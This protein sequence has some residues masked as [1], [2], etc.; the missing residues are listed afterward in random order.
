M[1]TS[2]GLFKT[3]LHLNDSPDGNKK[4]DCKMPHV[5]GRNSEVEV[6]GAVGRLYWMDVTQYTFEMGKLSP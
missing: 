6:S 4:D 1:Q 3:M 5:K 2:G